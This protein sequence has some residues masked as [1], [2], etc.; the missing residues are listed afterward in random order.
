VNDKVPCMAVYRGRSTW[1]LGDSRMPTSHQLFVSILI[2]AMLVA[3]GRNAATSTPHVSNIEI[4]AAT[5]AP[6]HLSAPALDLDENL[7]R[8]DTRFVGFNGFTCVAPGTS[9]GDA[10]LVGRYGLRCLEGTGDAILGP[11]HEAL[12]N[13]ANTYAAAYNAELLRR[14]RSGLIT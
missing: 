7:K 12:L 6:L 13:K 2:T 14:I 10:A 8:G 9:D 3:C 1:S 5:L 4:L 11:E